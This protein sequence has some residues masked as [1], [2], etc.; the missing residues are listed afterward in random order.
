MRIPL[1]GAL[2][3]GGDGVPMK[4]VNCDGKKRTA[5]LSRALTSLCFC[6]LSYLSFVMVGAKLGADDELVGGE[7]TDGEVNWLG[8][9][10]F[11][12]QPQ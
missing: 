9:Q 8:S 3:A 7:G 2:L 6:L 1:V 5:Q 11:A 12:L 4:G 10:S